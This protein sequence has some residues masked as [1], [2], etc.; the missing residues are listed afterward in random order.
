MQNHTGNLKIFVGVVNQT[1]NVTMQ[2]L[3]IAFSVHIVD[4]AYATF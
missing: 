4:G 2:R 1:T 3:Q